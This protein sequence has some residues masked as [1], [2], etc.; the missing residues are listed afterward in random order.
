VKYG[1]SGPAFI[2]G[3]RKGQV[4]YGSRRTYLKKIAYAEFDGVTANTT[5]V[6]DGVEGRLYQ[7][8][9]PWLMLSHRFTEHSVRES[10]GSTNP[11]I[12]FPD[13]A[14]F[15][16]KL[17]PM[18]QQRR[19]AEIFW[20]TDDSAQHQ[21]RLRSEAEIA[22]KSIVRDFFFGIDSSPAHSL[23][24]PK[25]RTEQLQTIVQPGAP[26][27]YGIVQVGSACEQGVPTVAI[28]DLCGEFGSELH[29][30]AAAIEERYAGSRIEAGDLLLSIK[31]TVGEVRIVPKHFRGNIS[32]DLARIRCSSLISPQLLLH[33][34]RSE[35]YQQY[36]AKFVVGSTRKEI[37]IHQLRRFE[38]P[39]PQPDA[40][41]SF[42]E[43]VDELG[44]VI[45]TSSACSD[46][47]IQLRN[48]LINGIT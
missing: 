3:F 13:I 1:R 18:D 42:L 20:A 22:Y 48:A 30:T 47:T 26:I 10:K 31:A 38:V 11:Y 41:A 40:A 44:K 23:F 34:F 45:A 43:S 28:K 4:L 29:K 27:R 8:L 15:Q 2:R 36:V 17:P 19:L 32:R 5:F 7:P 6:L 35:R 21:L 25:W 12:N 14:R 9:L 24:R 39:I 33:L 37:S 46:R 16:F